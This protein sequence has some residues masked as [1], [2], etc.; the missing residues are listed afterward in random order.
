MHEVLESELPATDA[1]VEAKMSRE[2]IVRLVQVG[3]LQGRRTPYGWMVDRRSLTAFLAENS[4][5]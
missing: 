4:V 5:A 1:A 3:R 2:R